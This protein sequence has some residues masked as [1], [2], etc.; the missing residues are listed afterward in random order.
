MIKRDRINRVVPLLGKIFFVM[1]LCL[2]IYVIVGPAFK[3]GLGPDPGAQKNLETSSSPITGV[4]VAGKNSLLA[5]N[6]D[7]SSV[8]GQGRLAVPSRDQLRKEVKANPHRTP[9]SILEFASTL[10][11]K[12]ALALKS[13]GAGHKFF[14][15][16]QRC[17]LNHAHQSSV[18]IRAICLSNAGL[19]GKNYSSLQVSYQVLLEKADPESV[20]LSHIP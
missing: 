8:M 11:P 6:S 20:R 12:M 3:V 4:Q 13:E 19:L 1:I 10:A 9:Q 16:L 5:L 2:G 14:E 18:V 15:E 17:V 7:S